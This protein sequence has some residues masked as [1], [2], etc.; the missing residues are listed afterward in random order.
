MKLLVDNH[1]Y[2]QKHPTFGWGD[3]EGGYFFVPEKGLHVIVSNG[4]GW[5]HVSV[6]HPSKIPTWEDMQFIK[7]LFFKPD[8]IV[9]QIHPKNC[10]YVNIHPNCLHLWR[11]QKEAIPTPPRYMV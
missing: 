2:R 3:H 1:K 7:D 6:S 11:P 9:M 8:E 4:D 5:D 10:D